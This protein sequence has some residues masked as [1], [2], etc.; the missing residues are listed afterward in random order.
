[1]F[2]K[3][4]RSPKDLHGVA[5][6][7]SQTLENKADLELRGNVSLAFSLTFRFGFAFLCCRYGFPFVGNHWI[8]HF[9]VASLRTEKTDPI[10]RDFLSNT[11]QYDFMVDQFSLWRVEGDEHIQLKTV[12][13]Q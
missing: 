8:P 13:F 10:I 3:S 5:H 11:E 9:S 12:N 4:I 7:V 6:D 2:Q 1:M